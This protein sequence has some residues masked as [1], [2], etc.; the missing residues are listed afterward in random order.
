MLVKWPWRFHTENQAIW[1]KVICSI[2]GPL[3]GLN[4]NSSLRPNSGPCTSFWNDIWIGDTPLVASF[5]RLY[6][7]DINLDCLVCDRNPTAHVS[8]SSIA[9]T[10]NVTR[11]SVQP[12]DNGSMS[13]D[14]PP[15]LIFQWV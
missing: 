14:F 15:G 3:G 9:T 6:R 10:S 2:H 4:D 1:R 13:L 5:P 11:H 12:T 8:L 7:L